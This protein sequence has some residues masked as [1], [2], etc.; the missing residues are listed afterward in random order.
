MFESR[1]LRVLLAALGQLW[2]YWAA[3]D[4]SDWTA[5]TIALTSYQRA[6]SSVRT[7]LVASAT[8]AVRTA[9][10]ANAPRAL[11]PSGVWDTGT[12]DSA[13]YLIS[14]ALGGDTLRA[15][16]TIPSSA[17]ALGAWWR[18]TF[19]PRFPRTSE[20]GAMLWPFD[21]EVRADDSVNAGLALE[22][23]SREVIAGISVGPATVRPATTTS[24]GPATARSVVESGTASS[25]AVRQG[26]SASSGASIVTSANEDRFAAR[27]LPETRITGRRQLWSGWQFLAL[28]LGFVS[29]GGVAVLLWRVMVNKKSRQR[30]RA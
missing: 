24:T 26:S 10:E 15:L 3:L 30:R 23:Y 9:V 12:R 4:R 22:A 19:A 7:E 16:G 18:G 11:A 1:S 14:V 5:A 6:W 28:S 13:V 17:G 2:A 20:I 27:Q 8:G 29:F 21:D 25:T